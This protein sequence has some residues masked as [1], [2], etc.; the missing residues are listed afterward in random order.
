MKISQLFTRAY[1]K[2]TL[3][4]WISFFATIAV[5]VSPYFASADSPPSYRQQHPLA[6][7]HDLPT[8][9]LPGWNRD[10]WFNFEYSNGNVWNAPLTMTDTKNNN[11]YEY[12]ADFEQNNFVLEFGGAVTK[13]FGASLEVPFSE[14]TGGIFDDAIDDFHLLI[15]GFRFNRQRH[16]ARRDTFSV[17]TNDVEYYTRGHLGDGVGNLKLKLKWWFLQTRGFDEGSCPCGISV[18]SQTK[19]PV[20]D[21]HYSNTNGGIDQTLLLH[22]GAP[23]FNSSGVWFT[24]GYTFLSAMESMKA[25]PRN[26]S[27][28]MYELNVDFGI[29]EGWGL[30]LSAR[31]ES[32][33]LDRDRLA[34]YD[35]EQNPRRWAEN[36]V[37]SGWNSLVYWRGSESLGFRYRSMAGNQWQ[38]SIVEDW[39]IG[40]HDSSDG[41][42]TN[43]APDVNFVLQMNLNW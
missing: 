4:K 25:W 14:R 41:R 19:F 27:I 32:P 42:Y 33:F 12:T 11:T 34:Y 20:Q 38:F 22:M 13:T 18:S 35:T 17:K 36:R 7:M 9:E 21:S 39:G 1:R 31:A 40:S 23:M 8:G 6:W 28:Q 30:I 10:T 15:G 16:A 26:H 43:D 2:D 29:S 3:M 24:A 5:V 37:A